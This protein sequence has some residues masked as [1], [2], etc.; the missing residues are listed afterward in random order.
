MYPWKWPACSE[1]LKPVLCFWG[2]RGKVRNFIYFSQA[3]GYDGA[4][5]IYGCSGQGSFGCNMVCSNLT[6]SD[7]RR[8][9][10]SRQDGHRM[11]RLLCSHGLTSPVLPVP[12]SAWICFCLSTHWLPGLAHNLRLFPVLHTMWILPGLAYHLSFSLG[13]YTV[14]D[15]C[16]FSH[17]LKLLPFCLILFCTTTSMLYILVT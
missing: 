15:Y 3:I 1:S 17:N 5:T 12:S 10:G 13:L 2:G 7:V 4:V 14:S 8:K 16:K 6:K 9:S 11:K